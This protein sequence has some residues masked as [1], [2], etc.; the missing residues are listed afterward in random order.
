MLGLAVLGFTSVYREGFEVVLFLQALVLEAGTATVLVGVAIGLAAVVLIGLAT[1]VMQ[2][3]LPYKKMLIVTGIMIAAVLLVMVGNTVHVMQVVG[4][5]SITPIRWLNPPYWFGIWF[6]I[7]P[8]VE[9]LLAQFLA[10]VYVLGSY[11]FAERQANKG[12][13]EKRAPAVT[14]HPVPPPVR[15]ADAALS[16][17]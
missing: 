8:T 17:K 12:N 10:L 7:Y 1:F 9:T 11:F 4:W 16:K 2:A 5:M 15:A 3:K 14:M 6:G 13:G